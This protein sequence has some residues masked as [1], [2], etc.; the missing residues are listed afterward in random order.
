MSKYT[1]QNLFR[2]GPGGN[3][4]VEIMKKKIILICILYVQ[5]LSCASLEP[6][7]IDF[8]DS[9]GKRDSYNKP[10]YNEL[11]S[12]FRYGDSR[13]FRLM[14]GLGSPR[15]ILNKF[16]E[17][18]NA[19]KLASCENRQTRIPKK[20][21]QIWV[22]KKAIP[23]YY[24]Q[25]QATWKSMNGWEYKLWTDED[26]RHFPLVN[27]ELYD[28][29]KNMGAKADILRLEILFKEGGLYVDT[30]FECLNPKMFDILH[31]T[32]DF[33]VALH[34][35]DC[36]DFAIN[37]AIIGVVPGHPII[38]SCIAELSDKSV[39]STRNEILLRGPGLLN[40]MT[41]KYMNLGFKDMI[42][43]PTFFYPLGVFQMNKGSFAGMSFNEET[44]EYIKRA[45]IKPETIAIHWW[46]SSWTG[47]DGKNLIM[48]K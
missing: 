1:K 9:L 2:E 44:F 23:E 33:Y 31:G 4:P 41:I 7:Q 5:V 43:P 14:K 34:P 12:Q 40:Y 6:Y 15:R 37:N 30:D 45:I 24:A 38:G 39:S 16:R 8:D 11:M 21:H 17:N 19:N 36:K 13:W 18:Y 42:F 28:Q 22:G 10:Y 47:P 3:G 20:I 32:Y 25:W 27:Q 35:L 29:E 46:D 48:I 26:V